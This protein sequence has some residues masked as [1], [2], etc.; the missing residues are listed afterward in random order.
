MVLEEYGEALALEAAFWVQGM[1]DVRYPAEQL[2]TL[3]L[4]LSE[5]FRTLAIL[6]LLVKGS[7][8]GF[9][10]HLI[11]SGRCRITYLERLQSM[12]ID[13]DHHQASGR[14]QPLLDAIASGE[15]RIAESI[16]A[17]SPLVWHE[18]REYEDDYCYAQ[19]LH[20]FLGTQPENRLPA[21]FERFAGSL[22]AEPDPRLAVC[23][24]LAER[25]SD[26]FA[27]AFTDLLEQRSVAI[28]EEKRRGRLEEPQVVA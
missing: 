4:N 23:E 8:D 1:K 16:A 2:G 22:E 9:H 19:A 10:H 24:A 12:G 11:R 18:Q 17:L 26:A 6:V 7:S 21:L 5:R 28:A 25:D 15:L 27:S 3:A 20:T 13:G 14:Y